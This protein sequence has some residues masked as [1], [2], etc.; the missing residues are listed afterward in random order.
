MPIHRGW[1]RTPPTCAVPSQHE[2]GLQG[3]GNGGFVS[4]DLPPLPRQS[5]RLRRK[6]RSFP[7]YR[8]LGLSSNYP[9]CLIVFEQRHNQ[10]GSNTRVHHCDPMIIPKIAFK[11]CEVATWIGNLFA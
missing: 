2:G 5:R 1:F 7:V 3:R 8:W 4:E 10:A 6:S 9:D 11:C